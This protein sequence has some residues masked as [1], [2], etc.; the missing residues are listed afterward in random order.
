MEKP[1][2][3]AIR[4]RDLPLSSRALIELMQEVLG[5]GLPFRFQARGWSMSPFIR[6]GDVI[7]IAPLLKASPGLGEVVAFTHP[8]TENLAVHR[9]VGRK[10]TGWLIRGD[11]LA[12]LPDLL[13]PRINILGRVTK[14]ERQDSRVWLGLGL[15]RYGITLLVRLGLLYPGLRLAAFLKN[16]SIG[17][18]QDDR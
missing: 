16:R 7:T 9:I 18:E 10:E 6:D 1:S 13:V 12:P 14:I 17:K 8:R 15:E 11:N 3:F 5:R 2:L 4:R